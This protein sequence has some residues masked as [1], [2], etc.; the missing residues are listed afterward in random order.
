MGGY[1]TQMGGQEEL[2]VAKLVACR[3]GAGT[4]RDRTDQ[5]SE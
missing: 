3:A 5:S 4:L 2:Q 1:V